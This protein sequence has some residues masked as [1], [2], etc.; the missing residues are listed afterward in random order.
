MP[1]K[2]D[3]NKATGKDVAE[4]KKTKEATKQEHEKAG[5]EEETTETAVKSTAKAGKRSKKAVEEEAEKAAKETKKAVKTDRDEPKKS[6]HVQNPKHVAKNRKNALTKLEAG[7]LYGLNEGIKLLRDIST[8]KFDATAE[9]HIRLNID[10]RQADQMV[11]TSVV[12]PAGSG[13]TIKVAVLAGDKQVE[14]AKKAGA[15][16]T[17]AENI[18]SDLKKSKFDFDVLVATPDQMVNL[19]KFAKVLGPKGLMPS[20]KSGTVTADPA[21][22]V[23]E[24]K[25]GRAELK[26]DANGIVHAGF[27][28]LSFSDENLFAN[29]AAVIN[30]VTRTKPSGVK[31][32]FVKSIT[33]ASTMS[34]GVR[35]DVTAVNSEIR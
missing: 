12:L 3:E 8:V 32:T 16:I 31:G 7:K 19:G 10:P 17:N 30:G 22:A 13:K 34:P 33:L 27:G 2:V 24:I 1:K 23:K 21:V 14:A 29:A 5:K 6:K 28:K 35:L 9:L 18:L 25:A 20:P 11:R 15:D 4:A 26:N